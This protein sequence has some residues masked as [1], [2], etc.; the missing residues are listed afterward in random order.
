MV[1]DDEEPSMEVWMEQV[2]RTATTGGL[3]MGTFTPLEGMSETAMLFY[4]KEI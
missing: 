4:P 3:Q 2:T 1:W